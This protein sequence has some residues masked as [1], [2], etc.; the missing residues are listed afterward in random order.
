MLGKDFRFDKKNPCSEGVMDAVR[1]YFQMEAPD[2][3]APDVVK[4]IHWGAGYYVNIPATKDPSG[5]PLGRKVHAQTLEQLSYVL[6]AWP[7]LKKWLPQEL[8]DRCLELCLKQWEPAGAFEIPRL[9]S[10]DTYQANVGGKKKNPMGGKL[11][12]YKGRHAPGHSIVPNLLMYEVAKRDD[13][14]NPKQYLK[15]A[16]AQ[17]KW[18]IKNIDW[19]DPRTTKGHRMSEHRTITNLVWMLQKYPEAA[20]NGLKA[21]IAEWVDVAI[22]RADNMWDFRRYDL[23]KNWTIPK[24]NDVGN[25][26]AL[27][28]ILLSASWIVDE[29]AKDQR[30]RELSAASI[31]H[32]FGRNPRLAAAPSQ[33]DKGFTG[34][35]RGWP[36]SHQHNVCARLETV[37][38]SISALPGSEM[39]PFQPEGRYRHAE[40]WVNYGANWCL[41]LAYLKFDQHAT[42]PDIN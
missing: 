38:S 28:A 14:K 12:P 37:R 30:L 22:S 41:T 7:K 5:D 33:P 18:I 29:H 24:L 19:N 26:I 20:P 6:W 42:T 40:G 35:E 34:I 2:P 27:P 21:K 9:W 13:L 4:L 16:I 1:G 25:S 11:H 32:V 17:S 39:Y 31:D 36:R 8:Y 23:D 10:M 3:D 15:A